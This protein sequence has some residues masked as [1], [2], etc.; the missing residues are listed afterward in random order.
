[1]EPQWSGHSVFGVVTSLIYLRLLIAFLRFSDAYICLCYKYVTINTVLLRE[2][3][4]LFRK[5]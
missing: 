3:Y 4:I 5:S 1:M 2:F